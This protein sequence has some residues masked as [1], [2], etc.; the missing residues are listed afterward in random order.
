M[1]T[2]FVI[3]SGRT[4]PKTYTWDAGIPN[5]LNTVK[6]LP[7]YYG[8]IDG[9]APSLAVLFHNKTKT[10]TTDPDTTAYYEWDF[11]DYYNDSTNIVRV[12][13]DDHYITHVYVMPGIYTVKLTQYKVKKKQVYI[14]NG[15]PCLG[16]YGKL[17]YWDKLMCS[18]IDEANRI[19]WDD[20]SCILNGKYTR[21]WDEGSDCL[22]KHCKSW[23]WSDL[24]K[25]GSNPLQWEK[26][27]VG[28]ENEKT[29]GYEPPSSACEIPDDGT[30]T[31]EVVEETVIKT[32][33]I[34]VDEILPRARLCTVSTVTQGTAPLEIEFTARKSIAG[35]FPLDKIEWYP[36]DGTG[37]YTVTRDEVPDDKYFI[38]KNS[39][40]NDKKDPRNYNFKYTYVR[41]SNSLFTYFPTIKIFSSNTHSSAGASTEVGPINPQ[42]VFKTT[43]P[44]AT[45][46]TS[47][48]YKTR[49]IGARNAKDNVLYTVQAGDQA[50][51]LRSIGDNNL[52][53]S[54]CLDNTDGGTLSVPPYTITTDC[55][56]YEHGYTGNNGDYY[57]P[58][59]PDIVCKKPPTDILP[60]P[61]PTTTPTPT[62][63]PTEPPPPPVLVTTIAGNPE[64]ADVVDGIGSNARFKKPFGCAMHSTSNIL[65]VIE[66]STH[67]IRSV[68]VNTQEVKTVAGFKN[69]PGSVDGVLPVLVNTLTTQDD[70]AIN[71]S[72]GPTTIARFNKPQCAAV[73]AN[74]VVYVCDTL[75]HTIRKID[76]TTNTVSTLAGV[77]GIP[78][79]VDGPLI[80][81]KFN[82]PHSI[83]IDIFGD[84]YVTDFFN[85]C[86]R[87]IDLTTQ[88]VTTIAGTGIAGTNDGRGS[89]ATFGGPAGIVASLD[90]NL[91]IT[92][93]VNH[94]IRRIGITPP[95]NVV[96]LAGDGTSGYLDGA[97]VFAKFHEPLGITLN[98]ENQLFVAD[99]EN[100]AIRQILTSYPF[101]VTTL[102][103]TGASGY[104]DG[105]GTVAQFHTPTGI[106]FNG[107]RTLY[108]VDQFNSVIRKLFI[109]PPT[110]TPT[111]T[112]TVTPTITPTPSI[113]P[114]NTPTPTETPT[115]TPTPTPTV[116]PTKT[117]TPTVT[118]TPTETPTQT[119]TPTV[120]PTRTPTPTVTPTKTSTP[121]VTPTK[122]PTQTPTNTPTPTE[123]PTQTPTNTVTPS[124]TPT[125]TVTP[126]NT[127]TQFLSP[128]PTPSITPT[129][130][131]TPTETPTRTPTQTPT[132][133]RTPT[134]TPTVT[135]TPT[136]TPTTTP[137]STVTPSITPTSTVTPSVTPTNTVTPSITPTNTVTPST[138][139]C[140]LVPF[141]L[142]VTGT[143][144][145]PAEQNIWGSN[146]YTADS[147]LPAAVVHAGLLAVG[148]TAL[149]K[150]TE[151]GQIALFYGNLQN[152]IMSLNFMSPFCGISLSRI[153]PII[154]PTPTL[155]P[156]PTVTPTRT[157]TTTP[158]PTVTPTYTITCTP[159]E[160][161][162]RTPTNT[163]TPSNTPTATPTKTPTATVTPTRT[164][165]PTKTET[166]TPTQTPPPTQTPT[167]TPTPT[168][169][170]TPT[171][172]VT[173]TPTPTVTPT[174]TETPTPTVTPSNTR[175]PTP[176]NTPTVTLTPTVT[177][178]TTLPAWLNWILFDAVWNDSKIWIDDAPWRSVPSLDNPIWSI[179]GT[180]T[181]RDDKIWMDTVQWKDQP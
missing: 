137:T 127:P 136:Q 67:I 179:F 29:W 181:W 169:S 46:E 158:T 156:T 104:R 82:Q 51:F 15:N 162:T 78:G 114:T 64:I 180:G 84:I 61:T 90:G 103:G 164:V 17:W 52:F 21:T 174:K 18:S 40:F 102:A 68:N 128:T 110:P 66:P 55:D 126:T 74:G 113:T 14:E 133:T 81:A 105:S 71:N 19:T 77:A 9:Y 139:A 122:T 33:V 177:P 3:L 130:T 157:S 116:T 76:F 5:T 92:D 20:T 85:R 170:A 89:V 42:E 72:N 10:D 107:Y 141:E 171:P 123:T 151:V 172:S 60:G 16:K 54:F 124:I 63:T 146:P 115:Q 22:Q 155:T 35:S 8:K 4:V 69:V 96:T 36:G 48:Q 88:L 2:E 6:V 31:Q 109:A 161:P 98:D 32:L 178:T 117:S 100:N 160:T 26:T 87:K 163:V 145:L 62:I 83:A 43:Y 53:E 176:T 106:V 11:G 93:V 7:S 57:P 23:K 75:N 173:R 129:N 121:T 12:F 131:P 37:P 25:Y 175:T 50:S 138:L 73:A 47:S 94:T 167:Q 135:R 30:Q 39:F 49:L 118:P 27:A 59:I 86:I 44:G 119:P 38:F 41:E 132:V 165:T 91:Y 101:T 153:G 34:Q 79:L 45:G 97:G 120:T 70:Q 168:S 144:I 125:N 143:D 134:Q 80:S 150:V 159:T 28:K 147:Y 142:Y 65:Y 13:C 95:H 56:I 152:G 140:G 1:T 58:Q 99:S 24:R 148:Q 112:R 111:P 108:I 166:P 149:I 154:T